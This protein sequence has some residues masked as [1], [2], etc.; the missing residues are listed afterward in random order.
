MAKEQKQD[1]KQAP[2]PDSAEELVQPKSYRL[3]I[4]LGLVGLLLFQM[5][6]LFFVLPSRA[7]VEDRFGLQAGQ[8][9]NGIDDPSLVPRDV[10]S[11]ERMVERPIRD[12]EKFTVSRWQNGENETFSVTLFVQVKRSDARRFDNQYE[13]RMNE[14]VDRI[15]S[16]LGGTT[17]EER[18]EIGNTAIKA[19]VQ[20]GINEVLGTPWVQQVFLRD[21][22]LAV[23]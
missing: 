6:V 22:S 20:R 12:G 21:P 15:T 16:I 10:V 18:Q 1:Q 14:V 5:I 8:A 9:A 3:Q 4:T 17:T 11:T 19:K 23:N 7:Q 13:L 2:A